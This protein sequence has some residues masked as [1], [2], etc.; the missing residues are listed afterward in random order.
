MALSRE[1]KE[2]IRNADVE[3]ILIKGFHTNYGGA[4]LLLPYLAAL[5][6]DRLVCNLGIEQQ[7]GI[8]TL[9]NV[10]SLVFLAVIGKKRVIKVEKVKDRGTVARAEKFGIACAKA[11]KK[12]GIFKGRTVNLDGHLISYF[13]DLKIV[14][15]LRCPCWK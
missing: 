15:E 4:F 9:Q 7:K 13:G 11:F 5:D 14:K 8:A 1:P 12:E 6:L 3:H 10:L 2:K